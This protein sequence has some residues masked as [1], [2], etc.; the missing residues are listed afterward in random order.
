MSRQS[1]KQST[2]RPPSVG[3]GGGAAR[4]ARLT[5]KQSTQA[6]EKEAMD[7]IAAFRA[8][9]AR[10]GQAEKTIDELKTLNPRWA[11]IFERVS[12]NE[13]QSFSRQT[14]PP[15]HF[16]AQG[17]GTSP[18]PSR[19]PSK[20]STQA[21]RPSK[22]STQA[23]IKFDD[24]VLKYEDASKALLQVL[25]AGQS[26]PVRQCAE[27][28]AEADVD[29]LGHLNFRQFCKIAKAIQHFMTENPRWEEVEAD[30]NEKEQR[31]RAKEEKMKKDA[32]GPDVFELL[33]MKKSKDVKDMEA[34][35]QNMFQRSGST[36]AFKSAGSMVM[37]SNAFKIK[38]DSS[39]TIIRR[40]STPSSENGGSAR[41]Q[42]FGSTI[43]EARRSSDTTMKDK[44]VVRGAGGFMKSVQKAMTIETSHR[45]SSPGPKTTS[46]TQLLREEWG[47]QVSDQPVC[48]GALNSRSVVKRHTIDIASD[49]PHSKMDSKSGHACLN[50]KFSE[51][52]SLVAGGFFDGGLRIYNTDKSQLVHCLNLSGARG[53]TRR[54]PSKDLSA[55]ALIYDSDDEEEFKPLDVV[56][57]LSDPAITCVRWRPGGSLGNAKVPCIATGDTSGKL[58]VWKVPKTRASEQPELIA[59]CC[60]TLPLDAICWSMDGGKVM[61]GGGERVIRCFDLNE[62]TSGAKELF[63]FGCLGEGVAMPGRMSGHALKIVS[64]CAHPTNPNVVFSG[65]IDCKCLIWDMRESSPVGS[66]RGNDISGDAIDINRFGTRLLT[67]SHRSKTPIQ[68]HELRMLTGDADNS[69]PQ[70]FDRNNLDASVSLRSAYDWRGDE[71]PFAGGARPTS[72]LPF[73]AAWDAFE[74]K[75]IVAAGEKENLARVFEMQPDPD[76]PLK[77]LGTFYGKEH[78]FLSAAISA[79]G[80]NAAFGS[81]DGGIL[82]V[83]VKMT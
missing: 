20:E 32:E 61:V 42:P 43:G 13:D 25:G 28:F 22:D 70:K 30:L 41:H 39:L 35:K 15:D 14:S 44:V 7:P 19:Q 36:G 81:A 49:L 53:G 17:S 50:L 78:A 63:N 68:V 59:S 64:L 75:T 71:I 79:D 27:Y 38:R 82:L 11:T 46:P 37:A 18:A 58:V 74:S 72:C 76:E 24:R 51:D 60:G 73:S 80:R 52:G 10:L 8:Q 34:K 6:K 83:D 21:G 16:V 62:G 45:P 40:P 33:G 47:Q 4:A 55:K 77:V 69:G 26:Y 65:G 3:G 57:D 2:G 31:E 67:G 1:S 56:R 66:I 23:N 9:Q 5:S 12:S 48:R 54:S 29:G